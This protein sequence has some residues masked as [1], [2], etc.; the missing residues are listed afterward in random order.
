VMRLAT[1]KY[2]YVHYPIQEVDED[3]ETNRSEGSDRSFGR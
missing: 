2:R 3:L 1:V